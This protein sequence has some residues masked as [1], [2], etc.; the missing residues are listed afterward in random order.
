MQAQYALKQCSHCGSVEE[1]PAKFCSN[2]GSDCSSSPPIPFAAQ[3]NSFAPTE[4]ITQVLPGN[5]LQDRSVPE[6]AHVHIGKASRSINAELNA[7]QMKLMVLLARER[8]FLYMHW[9][10]FIGI[11]FLGCWLAT[12][13]YYEFIG[14]ELSKLMIAST[15]FLF[16]NSL[17]LMCIVP[18]RGTRKEIARLKERLSYVRFKVEFGH[19]M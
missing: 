5:R 14:D 10:I 18:I 7:E 19:L 8:L 15:P 4:A 17:A 1:L 12:K 16:I 11:N 13:C 2:C 9:L 6:F 3:S